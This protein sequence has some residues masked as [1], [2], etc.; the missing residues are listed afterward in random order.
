MSALLHVAHP[1]LRSALS[2]VRQH[3]GDHDPRRDLLSDQR[4]L[5]A[6][7]RSYLI[8]DY[9]IPNNIS[10]CTSYCPKPPKS[11]DTH[12]NK[13][14]RPRDQWALGSYYKKEPRPDQVSLITRDIRAGDE[15]E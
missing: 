14:A 3:L 7:I 9:S 15:G 10:V 11:W 13:C 2:I 5:H 8:G 12:G 4:R 1:A 6:H